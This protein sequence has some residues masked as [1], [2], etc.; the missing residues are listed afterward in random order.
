M[1]NLSLLFLYLLVGSL[2]TAV[3]IPPYI[4]L[5]YRYN[6]GKK[7]REEWLIGKAVE[8]ARLH[9]SK[10]G[11]PTMWGGI[12][13]IVVFLLVIASMIVQYFSRDLGLELR[14]SLWNRN[15]T[16]IVLFTLFAVG[17]IG[18]V[19]DYLN[20]REIGRTKWLSA[21]VK[22]VLLFLFALVWA[23]WF[24]TKLWFAGVSL[25]WFGEITLG[26]LYIPLFMLIVV[27]MANSVNM[28]DGLDGLAW[29]ILL[30]NYGLYA[31]ISYD[32]WLTILSALCIIIAGALLSFLWW[33][34]KPAK[35]YMGDTGSL[36]LGATLAVIAMMTDTLVVLFVSSALFWLELLSVVVQL[37]SKKFRNGKKIFRIAPFHHHLEAIGWTEETIVMKF[38][39]IGIVLVALWGVISQVI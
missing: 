5:L 39:L 23:W 4:R 7:I 2:V 36:A 11:T 22:L 33:N 14:Y 21:R 38:W 6:I 3:L 10:I 28:T 20:V 34:I 16:Y 37:L 12:I 31:F 35:F 24:Y 19:D 13:L 8:F 30:L 26:W 15:E 18:I 32:K 1:S 17:A 27:T 9:A 25:P 29:G